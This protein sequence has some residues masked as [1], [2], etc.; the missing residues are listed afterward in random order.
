MFFQGVFYGSQ[1]HHIHRNTLSLKCVGHK[2]QT[3]AKMSE[4]GHILWAADLQELR[5]DWLCL[6]FCHIHFYH[7]KWQEN[8]TQY[9]IQSHPYGDKD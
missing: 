3:A 4:F 8:V 9:S 2:I 5:F 6:Q 7:E 1:F